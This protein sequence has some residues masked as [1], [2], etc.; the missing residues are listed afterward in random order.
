MVLPE[1]NFVDITSTP[2]TTFIRMIGTL[3][4]GVLLSRLLIAFT[5]YAANPVSRFMS[6]I[7][8][9]K[10]VLAILASVT[11]VT[12]VSVISASFS[13]LPHQ[14]WWGRVPA[15]FEAGAFTAL[16]YIVLSVSAFVS[17]RELGNSRIV[18]HSL[19]VTGILASLVGLFQFLGW[20]PLDISSTHSSKITGTNGNPIFFGAMLVI[21][22]PITIGV[23]ITGYRRATSDTQRLWLI[24]LAITSYLL[25]LSIFATGSRG[26]ILGVFAGLIT[27]LVLISATRQ[28]RIALIPFVL[29]TVFTVLGALTVRIDPIP[30]ARA[31]PVESTG[32]E[33]RPLPSSPL[34]DVTR[35]NTLDLRLRYWKLSAN[36]ALDRDPVPYTNDAPKV[37]R[38]LFG[39]GTDMFRF[40]GT[41]FADNTTFTRRLTAAHNDPINRLVEQGFLGLAAWVSLWLSIV[42]GAL[43]LVRRVRRSDSNLW[44]PITITAALSGRF[45]EQLFGS[46]TTGGVLLFWVLVGGLAAMLMRPIIGPG[47]SPAFDKPSTLRT[48]GTYAGVTVIALASIVLAWDKGVNYL[49]ANQMA[50]F[51]YRPTVVS[52]NEA[53]ERLERATDLAPDVPRYWN[54]LA[55]LEHG[56]AASTENQL[57]RVDALSKA[58]EYDLKAFEANPLEVSSV[59]SLAF[60]AWEAGNA[61]RPE[62]R[63]EAVRLYGYLTEIIPSDT[64]AQE[65]L[66]I[67][68]DFLEQ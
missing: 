65:R 6:E 38:W 23:L 49:I 55:Q 11:A 67:L 64:L 48:Y 61:G 56:R 9:N 50:S 39:Y 8:A 21:L 26:P 60:S 27:A 3:Q 10:P 54:D 66:Q 2:K 20:S 57:I 51:Q 59:Y 44:I 46:P 34:S 41:Y 24:A 19:A 45:V 37:V 68:R 1:S 32:N 15:G 47:A 58:Y 40:S 17:I 22:A 4:A 28:L 42:Y 52:A 18:W 62:L 35:S 13:I 14:S 31:I 12:A 53:I 36:M 43:V 63:Q 5:G 33:A 30:Q 25:S 16:M 29:I 7:K